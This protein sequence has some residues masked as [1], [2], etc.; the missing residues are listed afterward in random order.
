VDIVFPRWLQASKPTQRD[1]GIDFHRASRGQHGNANRA[2]RVSPSIAEYFDRAMTAHAHRRAASMPKVIG[3]RNSLQRI[4]DATT[5]YRQLIRM[6]PCRC[7]CTAADSIE[8]CHRFTMLRAGGIP[9][10]NKPHPFSPLTH[11]P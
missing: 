10:F 5:P 4:D 9:F 6:D 3:G 2:T 8:S 11:S 1:H 7:R